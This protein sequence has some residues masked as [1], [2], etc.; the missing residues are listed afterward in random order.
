[1]E[2]YNY[3]VSP[4]S[5]SAIDFPVPVADYDAFT[6][7]IPQPY[8][9]YIQ[10]YISDLSPSE[11]YVAY[12]SQESKY[13][14]GSTRTATVYNI[15]VGEDLIYTGNSFEGSVTVYKIYTNTNYFNQFSTVTDSNFSLN[16]GTDLVYT[17]I[18]SPYPDITP[19]KYSYYIFVLLI[20]II[21][22]YTITS[23][24]GRKR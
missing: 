15:A 5:G 17:N 16:P 3:D 1:M 21:L 23:F 22:F 8:L 7:V 10:S 18:D 13:V 11:C 4:V 19:D 24:F 6:A 12:V 20:F 14:S 9:E 2:R